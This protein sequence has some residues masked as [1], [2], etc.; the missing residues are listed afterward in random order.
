MEINTPAFKEKEFLSGLLSIVENKY[1]SELRHILD[2][3]FSAID[4]D[5]A[6]QIPSLKKD[7]DN[8]LIK[9][10]ISQWFE[11]A[12]VR[13]L[14]ICPTVDFNYTFSKTGYEKAIRNKHRLKHFCVEHWKYIVTTTIAFLGI[15][16]AILA[17]I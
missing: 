10:F 8:I 11:E 14:V 9:K 6:K 7:I 5:I 2:H 4:V 15:I 17:T 16:V 1:G 3:S 12:Q 13:G